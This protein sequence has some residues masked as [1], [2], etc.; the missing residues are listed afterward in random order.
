MA[1][2]PRIE[3]VP[4]SKYVVFP[5]DMVERLAAIEDGALPAWTTPAQGAL[6]EFIYTLRDEARRTL[7][8]G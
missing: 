1:K 2:L 3:D 7:N 4:K 6:C 5:R 8:N